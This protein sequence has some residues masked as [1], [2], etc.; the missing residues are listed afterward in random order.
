VVKKKLPVAGSFFHIS[1]ATPYL[2][3]SA[4]YQYSGGFFLKVTVILEAFFF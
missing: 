1:N 4:R 2:K 3:D